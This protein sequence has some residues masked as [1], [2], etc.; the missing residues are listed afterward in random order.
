MC[1]F[2]AH[3]DGDDAA[4]V[5]DEQASHRTYVEQNG[6]PGLHALPIHQKYGGEQHREDLHILSARALPR[7]DDIDIWRYDVI[8]DRARARH[9]G[10]SDA[11]PD[12]VKPVPVRVHDIGRDHDES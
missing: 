9:D 7:D 1:F 3:D 6:A 10:T 4:D 8:A 2:G 11:S 12:G 5:D